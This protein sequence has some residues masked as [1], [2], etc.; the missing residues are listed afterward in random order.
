M[1]LIPLLLNIENKEAGPQRVKIG[2]IKWTNFDK[3]FSA[4]KIGNI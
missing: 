2:P 3:L 4:W 1:Y